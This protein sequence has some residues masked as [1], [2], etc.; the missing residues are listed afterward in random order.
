[1]EEEEGRGTDGVRKACME[2]KTR[3]DEGWEEKGR[4]ER[5]AEMDGG[6]VIGCLVLIACAKSI[7]AD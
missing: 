4:E 7:V 6:E 2:Q 1:M 5:D 3:G